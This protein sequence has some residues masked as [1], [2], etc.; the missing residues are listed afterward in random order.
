MKFLSL[1]ML[2]LGV[3]GIGAAQ[4]PQNIFKPKMPFANGP[5]NE[6]YPGYIIVKYKPSAAAQVQQR[7]VNQPRAS[8]TAQNAKFEQRMYD[9]GWTL[10]SFSPLLSYD[11]IASQFK[12]DPNVISVQHLN[13]VYPLWV[14]PNDLDWNAIES[15]DEFILD[16][17]DNNLSFK[18]LWHL[19]DVNAQAGW[20][21]W[22]NT[23]YTAATKP[24]N[25]PLMAIIDTGCDMNHP[26][27]MN[28]GGT[29]TDYTGG[30]QLFKAKSKFFTFGAMAGSNAEDK[31]GHGTHVAG[32]ALAAGNNDGFVGH[33]VIGTGYGARGMILRVFDNSGNGSDW[34]SAAAM[35]YAADNKVAVMNLSLGT[36]N[37]SQI[38]QDATTYAFQKGSLVVAAG[39]E[40]GSGGGDLGPIYPAACSG[41]LGVAAL[42]P[43]KT[44]A[45]TYSGA[46]MFVD[47]AAPGGDV[48]TG[49]DYFVIQYVFSTS[50]RTFGQLE[51]MSNKGLIYPPYTENY[52]YLVGTSMACPVVSGAAAS[53][54]GRMGYKQGNWYNLAA[55][56]AIEKS[57]DGVMGA[58]HGGWEPY[59]G[60]G[61]LDMDALMN[62][63]D[64]RGSD[65][66]GMEGI[67]YSNS[68][69]TANV[70][71]KARRLDN[72]GVP[73]G[74][75]YSTTTD[76]HGI[77][78][79]DVLP[80]GNYEVTAAPNGLVKKRRLT[81]NVGCD[82]T[83]LDFWC[84]TYT[85]D[86][87]DPVAQTLTV[88]GAKGTKVPYTHWAYDPE[89]GIDKI[90][91]RVGTTAG[92]AE[93]M[94]DR[95]VTE[96]TFKGTV[97][98]PVSMVKGNTYYL[99]GTYTNGNGVSV[100]KTVSFISK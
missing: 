35:Y 6:T 55:Y 89:T 45:S 81:I 46:G 82:F 62:G 22:P 30:G 74:I 59:M 41:A 78:R 39:N 47:V 29:T 36:T 84:G 57:A 79:F 15:S 97:V 7:A 63:V 20:S 50:M 56:Q 66:G 91:Y 48:I 21:V 65:G 13:H 54:F 71:V 23:W 70:S 75:N 26:D 12:S 73:F 31:Q 58:A 98:L 14:D 92:G 19:D 27:F 76:A 17:G 95:E 1:S 61:A 4:S 33:G 72:N 34:D 67:V 40:S 38:F 52:S 53:Y 16:F 44:W 93:L 60:Y 86:E 87:T 11:T 10:W 68:T 5:M 9:T 69:P 24:T 94:A 85:G 28:A 99:T 18:R 42:G 88:S 37:Y 49:A 80:K 100:Q 32:I 64:T 2:L 3:V 25:A 51:D 96:R 77:Y 43:G 90:A 83:G 8:L